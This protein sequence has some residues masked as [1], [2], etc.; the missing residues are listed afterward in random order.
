MESDK[1]VEGSNHEEED[2]DNYNTKQ[3][4]SDAEYTQYS[5]WPE[6]LYESSE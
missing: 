2:L 5:I 6:F 3:D 4:I 1:E